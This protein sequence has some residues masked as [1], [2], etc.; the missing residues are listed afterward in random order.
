M[1]NIEN[2]LNQRNE[3]NLNKYTSEIINEVSENVKKIGKRE[4]DINKRIIGNLFSKIINEI[5]KIIPET[6]TK[7][8]TD[9]NIG[10]KNIKTNTGIYIFNLIEFVIFLENNEMIKMISSNGKIEINILNGNNYIYR[11]STLKKIQDR[12]VYSNFEKIFKYIKANFD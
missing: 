9:I 3:I 12:I 10:Y 7:K 2:L 11:N 4:K 6:R 1:L 8:I 5:L